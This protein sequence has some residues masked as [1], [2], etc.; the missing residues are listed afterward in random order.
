MAV[1]PAN[2][3][4]YYEFQPG[5]IDLLLAYGWFRM[6]RY[7][8][9]V[10]HI[11]WNR[12][13][14]VFWLRYRLQELKLPDSARSIGKRAGRFQFVI[15]DFE[16]NRAHDELYRQYRKSVFIDTADQLDEV[17]YRQE[18]GQNLVET[19]PSKVVEMWDGNR[20]AGAGI[21]DTGETGLMGIVNYFHPDYRKFSP[22]KILML[23]K[24]EWAISRNMEFYY[25]GYIGAR[26]PR[27]D[28]KLFAGTEGAEIYDPLQVMWLPYEKE[29]SET[30]SQMQS[31]I[32][33]NLPEPLWLNPLQAG[34]VLQ[35]FF[36][37]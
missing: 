29:V 27:F 30:L 10:H 17:L 19:F 14:R 11:G 23:K 20:L 33:R 3:R 24:I 1:H 22:G 18:A 34:V 32:I 13:V 8:F 12:D 9:T 4:P 7:M 15:R 31:Q 28:Y 21:F 26:D 25:P 2:S 16:L 35:K 5:H 6:G 37:E 36:K